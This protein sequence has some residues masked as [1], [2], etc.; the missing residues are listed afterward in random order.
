MNQ[1]TQRRLILPLLIALFLAAGFYFFI[2]RRAAPPPPAPFTVE[3][4]T[5]EPENVRVWTEFSG[6]LKEVDW[7]EIRPEVNGRIV[8]VRFEDG[9]RV[10]VGDVLFVIDPRPYEAAV[11]KAEAEV[12]TAK[13][14][15]EFARLEFERGVN[16]IKTQAI[17]QRIYDERYN[18]YQVDLAA[19]KS[20]EAQL[21]QA[22]VD[23]EHA[24]VKSP[25]SGRASR[26][27]LTL[28]NVVQSGPNA[29]LMTRILS[30]DPVYAD[31]DVDDQTYLQY[32]RRIAYIPSLDKEIP[33]KLILPGDTEP[34]FT[35]TIYSFDN[36]IDTATGT[37]RA[38]AKFD[39]P[40][41]ILVPGMYVK[42]ELSEGLER[43]ALLVPQQAIGIDQ[44][45]KVVY[46]VGKDNKVEYRGVELGKAVGSERI[47]LKGLEAGDR[48]IVT[49]LQHVK[50][51]DVV[52]VKETDGR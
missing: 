19:I 9:A 41:G 7:A 24:Y 2:E 11:A 44:N 50:P 25:I 48:V 33:V 3:V 47:V 43:E 42:V 1:I 8:E 39:N 15:A 13:A 52:K 45:K 27:E 29:P 14:N 35:G 5:L 21:K 18:T 46:V 22:R 51:G 49:G 37:I 17:A 4:K 12:A 34:S 31:F 30:V 32:I 38:R 28:G 36:R 20:A 16:M 6:R 40:D 23:L 26:V 10:K